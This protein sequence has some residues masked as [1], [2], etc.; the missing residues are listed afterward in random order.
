MDDEFT[1]SSLDAKWTEQNKP[2]SGGTTLTIGGGCAKV[3]H[4]TGTTRLY[5]LEQ[6]IS[7]GSWRVRTKFRWSMYPGGNYPGTGLAVKDSVSGRIA[8]V[9]TL[10][11]STINSSYRF[12][13]YGKYSAYDTISTE[14]NLQCLNPYD[15]CYLE[16]EYDGTNLI[17]RSAVN[18]VDFLEVNRVTVA[19][20]LNATPTHVALVFHIYTVPLESCVE[21]FRRMA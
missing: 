13:Y 5:A 21:W 2:G 17:W 19:S 7:G 12:W 18:G 3:F 6:P 15:P 20:F 10:R 11:H 16:M 4:G 1:G 9:M 8:N 14:T